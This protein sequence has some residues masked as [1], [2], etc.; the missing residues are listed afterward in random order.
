MIGQIRLKLMFQM[1]ICVWN[2]DGMVL[3]SIII[4]VDRLF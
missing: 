3:S 4:Y 2:E 1:D